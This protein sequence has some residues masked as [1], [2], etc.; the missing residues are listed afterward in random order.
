MDNGINTYLAEDKRITPLG[1]CLSIHTTLLR[2]FLLPFQA[3]LFQIFQL[4]KD[5]GTLQYNTPLPRAAC[6]H[7]HSFRMIYSLDII[8]GIKKQLHIMKLNSIT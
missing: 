6:Q 5:S 4:S 2:T 3:T 7:A 1:L 8:H